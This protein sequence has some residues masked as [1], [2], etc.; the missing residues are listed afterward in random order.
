MFV[1]ISNNTTD[2]QNR[3]VTLC[4]KLTVSKRRKQLNKANQLKKLY[5][6]SAR[7]VCMCTSGDLGCYI[8]GLHTVNLTTDII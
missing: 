3:I 1:F 2:N 6:R 5:K 4:H 7:D 8:Y